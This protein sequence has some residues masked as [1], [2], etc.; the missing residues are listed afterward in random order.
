MK[1]AGFTLLLL[2]LLLIGLSAG[3]IDLGNFPV[4]K[5]VD[6]RY[7]AVWTFSTGNI[8][9]FTTGGDL[10]FDFDGKVDNFKVNG[11]LSGVEITFS[12]KETGRKYKFVKGVSNLDLQMVI[13]KDSGVHYDTPLK[14][15]K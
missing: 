11:S 3:D 5:W 7:E 15:Q 13:D 14:I 12:C 4:G 2:S 9:L 8:Q 6:S 1:K 10:V